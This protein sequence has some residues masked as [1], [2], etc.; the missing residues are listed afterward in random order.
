LVLNDLRWDG[1]PMLLETPKEDDLKEDLMNLRR[2][3]ALL[4][5]TTRIPVGLSAT[6]IEAKIEA[7]IETE[8]DPAHLNS[9]AVRPE[10]HPEMHDQ[11]T[12]SVELES[13]D[14]YA[15]KSEEISA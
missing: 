8:N 5:D 3:C 6:E 1:I 2:L 12:E 11:E 10:V 9:I 4:E 7:A 13:V 15:A 14:Y